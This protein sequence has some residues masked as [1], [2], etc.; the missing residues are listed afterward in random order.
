MYIID[1]FKIILDGITM[2][3]YVYVYN[4]KKLQT[5]KLFLK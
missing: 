4:E 3:V 2:Y 1:I 5:T